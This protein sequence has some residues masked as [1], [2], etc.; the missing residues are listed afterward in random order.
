MDRSPKRRRVNEPRSL[1]SSSGFPERDLTADEADFEFYEAKARNLMRRKLTFDAIFE[2]YSKD[3][4][5]VGDEINLTTGEI[6]VNNGHLTRMRDEYDV[7]LLEDDS[8]EEFGMSLG[9]RLPPTPTS[10]SSD[11][12]LPSE[13]TILAQFGKMLGPQVVDF[14]AHLQVLNSSSSKPSSKKQEE[15]SKPFLSGL[16]PQ[17][18][19]GHISRS[20]CS[21]G[22]NSIWSLDQPARER[23]DCVKRR[24]SS[25]VRQYKLNLPQSSPCG[26]RCLNKEKAELLFECASCGLKYSAKKGLKQHQRNHPA[27]KGEVI[28][29]SPKHGD[30]GPS[31]GKRL[32]GW[33]T[34]GPDL[35]CSDDELQ[36]GSN[37]LSHTFAEC[38]VLP[39][40]PP[41]EQHIQ[42]MI[43]SNLPKTVSG[44]SSQE[45]MLEEISA[46]TEDQPVQ[47]QAKLCICKASSPFHHSF[48]V[49][50]SSP[51]K[52]LVA[53]PITP[54]PE[55][56]TS[57]SEDTIT[58]SED[59]IPPSEE[60]T[61]FSK[62]EAVQEPEQVNLIP[63]E[64]ISIPSEDDTIPR[65]ASYIEPAEAVTLV[66]PTTQSCDDDGNFTIP[67]DSLKTRILA[68]N[69]KIDATVNLPPTPC[70]SEDGRPC[71]FEAN[72][73]KITKNPLILTHSLPILPGPTKQVD[74][75]S[76]INRIFRADRR[77]CGDQKFNCQKP[78][79]FNC[80]S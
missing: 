44:I 50:I 66:E 64:V 7:N 70:P 20:W 13:T 32:R 3:F 17:T 74:S 6:V 52:P 5:T 62:E 65:A 35:S 69:T 47:L 19:K 9:H 8:D 14:V 40:T 2:K 34:N 10:Q 77:R 75:V 71:G 68:I 36:L 1:S 51:L 28:F 15:S 38:P 26:R 49:E 4:S 11:S 33:Q 53:R 48:R 54:P 61:L 43:L 58:L 73:P 39:L 25:L 37:H 78:F 45:K 60:V 23:Q 16:V 56:I 46:S 55:Y 24:K 57:L 18:P 59:I 42:S 30:I 67:E 63:K 41:S 22:L 29:C 79:C 12:E 72:P 80:D 21:S 31:L 27:C 76:S